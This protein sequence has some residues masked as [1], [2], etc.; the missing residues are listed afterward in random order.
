MNQDFLLKTAFFSCFP[1]H[2]VF[3]VPNELLMSCQLLMQI[4]KETDAEEL[5]DT[6]LKYDTA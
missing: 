3:T 6:Q 5:I 1:H 2:R 4:E